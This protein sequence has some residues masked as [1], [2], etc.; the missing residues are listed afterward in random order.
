MKKIILLVAAGLAVLFVNAQTVNSS[1]TKHNAGAKVTNGGSRWYS[2]AEC[3]RK[4]FKPYDSLVGY[5][6][7]SNDSYWKYPGNTEDANKIVSVAMVC[8]PYWAGFND[9][10]AYP[11]NITVGPL[12][13]YLFDSV[14][15]TGAYVVAKTGVVDTLILSFYYGDLSSGS[16]IFQDRAVSGNS[17]ANITLLTHYSIPVSDTMFLFSMLFDSLTKTAVANT[18]GSGAIKSTKVLLHEADTAL[19]GNGNFKSYR[20]A[21]PNGGLTCPAG[22]SLMGCSITFRSGDSTFIPYDTVSGPNGFKYNAF[23]PEVYYKSV[24]ANA[25]FP[26]YSHP[27]LDANVGFFRREPDSIWTGRYAP[28]FALTS[29]NGTSAS[30]NQYLGVKFHITCATCYFP[31][32]EFGIGAVGNS[33]ERVR[34]TPNPA[35]SELTFSFVA[36]YRSDIS[37]ALI[38]TL[39]E[40]VK[41]QAINYITNGKVILNINDLPNGAYYYVIRTEG[42]SETGLV[43]VAH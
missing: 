13:S 32:I 26:T 42:E 10:I 9:S 23:L 6:W 41:Q 27:A 25:V 38:N 39:G 14:E 31:F 20:F 8:D 19:S 3:L 24:G 28:M 40:V 37:L 33:C 18:G 35:N 29:N 7:F 12:D 36:N 1:N 22:H 4:N 15:I 34:I 5:L 11:W 17:P 16:N 30:Q 43:V 2:Y 21:V